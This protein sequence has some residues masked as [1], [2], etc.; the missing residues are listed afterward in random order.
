M[1]KTLCLLLMLVLLGGMEIFAGGGG[2]S[3]GTG[4]PA[5]GPA[6]VTISFHTLNPEGLLQRD[7]YK[8][9]Q[10]KA[11]IVLEDSYPESD[12][13]AL[14]LASGDLPDIFEGYNIHLKTIFDNNYALD[15]DTILDTHM[16]NVK[17]PM[18]K[19]RNDISRKFLGGSNNHLYVLSPRIGPSNVGGNDKDTRGYVV[20]WD[21]YKEIGAPPINNDDD[22]IAAIKEMLRRHPTTPD[23]KKSQG[24]G[25]YFDNYAAYFEHGFLKANLNKYLFNW[26]QYMADFTTNELINGFMD[27]QRSAGWLDMKFY[28]KVH[29][30]GLLDMDS[31]IMKTPEYLEKVKAGVYM[32]LCRGSED[33]YNE[34]VTKDPNTLSG[35]VVVPSPAMTQQ[36]DEPRIFGSA[37]SHFYIIN[38]KSK[39]WEAA[40]K[41][42]NIMHDPDTIRTVYSGYKGTHWDYDSKGVPAPFDSTTALYAANPGEWQ[43]KGFGMLGNFTFADSCATH[44][45]GYFFGLFSDLTYRSK[46]SGLNPLQKDYSAFY[47]V[48]YPAEA[49]YKLVQEGKAKSLATSFSDLYALTMADPP[50]DLMRIYMECS[51]IMFRA[52]SKAV[53]APDDAAFNTIVNQTLADMKAAGESKIWDW[54]VE[55]Y[56]SGRQMFE[57]IVNEY[58][59]THKK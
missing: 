5:A 56:N 2:Q 14:M 47:K 53:A 25:F 24:I 44:P 20:R 16:P 27:V 4:T 22:Y 42:F 13:I 18:Y 8:D 59:S 40:A 46:G 57:P 55:R 58:L 43:G 35:Y 19:A 38:S 29:K 36:V 39:N 6:K 10:K 50:Q 17:L 23:G 9:I 15:L 3:G 32:A 49:R 34:M 21:Y 45:D 11:N 1:K 28:N 7:V 48:N 54:C 26:S 31:F 52:F 33:F 37:P 41:L 30:E 12:Q 51:D